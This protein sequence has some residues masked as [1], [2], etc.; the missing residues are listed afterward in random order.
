MNVYIYNRRNCRIVSEPSFWRATL[1]AFLSAVA[2]A[3]LSLC[4]M[5]RRNEPNGDNEVKVLVAQPP[6]FVAGCKRRVALLMA[7]GYINRLFDTTAIEVANELI[8]VFFC[9]DVHGFGVRLH[10]A[11]IVAIFI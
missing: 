7:T 4:C 6:V 8:F 9:P 5:H 10:P 3:Y 1:R 2:N 11:E